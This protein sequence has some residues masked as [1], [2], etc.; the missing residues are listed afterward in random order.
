MAG[1]PGPLALLL[2]AGYPSPPYLKRGSVPGRTPGPAKVAQVE[3]K[4][5][6]L[7]RDAVNEMTQLVNALDADGQLA[8]HFEERLKSLEALFEQLQRQKRGPR[9]GDVPTRGLPSTAEGV[10]W[11]E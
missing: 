1:G 9:E 3:A 4:P 10:R 11:R 2:S 8:H 6:L 7:S 5:S